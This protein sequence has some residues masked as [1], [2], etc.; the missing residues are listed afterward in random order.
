M[1]QMIAAHAGQR[2]MSHMID[3]I[4]S[5]EIERREQES[6]EERKAELMALK[7]Q[8]DIRHDRE[9]TYWHDK[10][11]EAA[12]LYGDNPRRGPIARALWGLY[13]MFVERVL[14]PL[15]RGGRD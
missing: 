1:A 15:E 3:R 12:R 4:V 7:A 13:G 8:L 10:I 5:D 2:V 9:Q 6:A 11:A 14:R